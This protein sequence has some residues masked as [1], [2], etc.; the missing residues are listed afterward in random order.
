MLLVNVKLTMPGEIAVISPLLLTEAIL[1]LLL[2][3]VPPKLGYKEDVLPTQ[4]LVGPVN[5]MFNGS[6]TSIGAVLF[7]MHEVLLSVN[8]NVVVPWLMPNTMPLLLI[9]AT[10]GLLLDHVPPLCG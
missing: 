8:L 10:D 7:E 5:P 4:I 1:E 9:T 6:R 3:H 2:V